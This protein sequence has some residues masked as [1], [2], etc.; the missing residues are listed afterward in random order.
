MKRTPKTPFLA[1]LILSLAW[2]AACSCND[3]EDRLAKIRGTHGESVLAATGAD[4]I[5]ESAGARLFREKTCNTCHGDD[6]IHPLLPDYPILAR[7]GR[8]YALRQMKDIQSG[9]RASGYAPQMQAVIKDVTEDEFIIL[10]DFIA[11][12]LGGGAPIGGQPDPESP[13]AKLFKT[14]TC[15][16]CHGKDGKTPILPDYP[17]IAGL[18][19]EYILR[20]MRDIK[21]GARANSMAVLGMQGVMHLVDDEQMTQL[22]DYVSSL[23]K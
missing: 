20:Q 3:R 7:Q 16:A 9:N 18:P 5:Q 2:L 6:G 1:L 11:N 12:E 23:P 19:R 13:G 4:V 15:T 10:A 21:S 14:K 17:R 8:D 22:A